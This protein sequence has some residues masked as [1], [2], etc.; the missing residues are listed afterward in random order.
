MIVNGQISILN[1]I[2]IDK[3]L[4]KHKKVETDKNN[5]N[6]SGNFISYVER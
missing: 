3:Q 6:G 1:S 4:P 5:F 2:I